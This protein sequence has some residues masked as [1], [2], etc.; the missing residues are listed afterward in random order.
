MGWLSDLFGRTVELEYRDQDGKPV[1][2]RVSKVQFDALMKN[3]VAEGKATVHETCVV[4]ILDPKRD[5]PHH[6]NWIIGEQV[7]RETYDRLKQSNGHLYVMVYYEKGEPV[8]QAIK[9]ELW[10][11]AAREMASITREGEQA[12][13]KFTRDFL[14]E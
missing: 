9:K 1:K 10:M 6:E 7:P 4:H 2:K 12:Y 11:Q 13:Q 8:I 5:R 3:A 14:G